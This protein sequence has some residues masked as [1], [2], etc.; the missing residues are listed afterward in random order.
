MLSGTLYGWQKKRQARSVGSG[1]SNVGARNLATKVAHAK[2]HL[3]SVLFFAHASA[4][5]KLF[6]N[7]LELVQV[8]FAH[9]SNGCKSLFYCC[10]VLRICH[11]VLCKNLIY[12][13]S[14]LWRNCCLECNCCGFYGF[15]H[16]FE[17]DLFAMSFFMSTVF[18]CFVGV[19]SQIVRRYICLVLISS[20]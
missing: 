11:N 2:Q 6:M 1:W 4:K 9:K 20:F 15:Y 7:K 14:V 19:S 17:H 13:E 12:G 5:K 10:F 18:L 3:S 16:G 8:T